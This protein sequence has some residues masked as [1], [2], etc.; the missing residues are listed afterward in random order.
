MELMK[1]EFIPKLIGHKEYALLYFD[2][3]FIKIFQIL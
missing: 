1:I 2:S 3:K